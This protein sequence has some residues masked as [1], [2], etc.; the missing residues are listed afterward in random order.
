MRKITGVI[1]GEE[2][3]IRELE[4]DTDKLEFICEHDI[5]RLMTVTFHPVEY[6]YRTIRVSEGLL[7]AY[8][9]LNEELKEGTYQI[10]L[11]DVPTTIL[12]NAPEGNV[13]RHGTVY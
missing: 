1:Q 11:I 13:S 3:E 7:E 12:P 8:L 2:F 9:V 5:S 10:E 4:K 6:K